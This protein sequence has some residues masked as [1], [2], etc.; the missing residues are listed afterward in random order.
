MAIVTFII[1]LAVLILV[2]EFG[3]FLSAKLFGV[4]VDEFGVG[5]PPRA[6]KL[7]EWRQTLFTLNWL[8]FGGFVKIFGENGEKPAEPIVASS[9]EIAPSLGIISPVGKTGGAK[10]DE[11]KSFVQKTRPVQ[12]LILV[13]GVAFNILLAWLLISFG[14]VIGLPTSVSTTKIGQVE[15]V[16]LVITAVTPDSPAS[17][18]GIKSGDV[19]TGVSIGNGDDAGA[20][21]NGNADKPADAVSVTNLLP[22]D[23]SEF[24]AEHG[25]EKISFAFSRGRETGTTVVTPDDGIIEG[26]KAVGISMDMI[27][28]LSLPV[29]IALWEGAKTTASLTKLV[30]VGLGSFVF[31]AFRGASD[32]SQVTGPVGI[33]GLVGDASKLG[34]IYLISFTAFISINLAVINLVPFPALDGGRLLF[35][36]IESVKRSPISPKISNAMN[37]VGFFLLVGLMIFVT[38]HDVIKLF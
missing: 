1:I 15:N 11:G 19:I 38:I 23:V 29:H 37:A 3:H 24:I 25:D 16:R 5:Y 32:L 33:V 12:A 22:Q 13:A 6:L 26:R 14:Y 20:A 30:A 28:I 35:V 18:G 8:P 27:G 31:D 10:S 4:R 21:N 2:H 9:G 36:I 17:V 7:F 34:F